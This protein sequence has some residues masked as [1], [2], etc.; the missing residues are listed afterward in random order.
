MGTVRKMS[1]QPSSVISSGA[2]WLRS[3]P[4]T[5]RLKFCMRR[6]CQP[7]FNDLNQSRSV[8]PL[9]RTSIEEGVRWKT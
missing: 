8:G 2:A 5:R 7:G 4:A 3:P 6:C 1:V 9:R